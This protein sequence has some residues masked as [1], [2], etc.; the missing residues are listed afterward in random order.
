LNFRASQ[1]IGALAVAITSVAMVPATNEA[2]A[3]IASAG[4]A[5][6]FRH[7]M[8][9]ETGHDRRRFARHVDQNGGGRAAVL[10]AVEN[11]GQH[12][13]R[14][15]RRQRKRERQQDRDGRDRR[16]AGQ[17]A[18]Q[19]SDQCAEKTEPKVGGRERD[20]EAGCKI[21]EEVHA[22]VRLTTARS[23]SAS[24]AP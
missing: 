10:R 20:R 1:V 17:H 24:P 15:R 12:D 16:D 5:P 23:G 14:R 21:G 22:P 6:L 13:Q 18:D 3:A 11:S 2:I 8:A 4:P 9:V 7:L 19:R